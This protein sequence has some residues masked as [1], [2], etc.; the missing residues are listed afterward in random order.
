VAPPAPP[1]L[2]I[3][4]PGISGALR[5]DRDLVAGLKAGGLA[6][7]AEIV[8]WP[9]ENRGLLALGSAD[10]NREQARLLAGRIEKL[11]RADPRARIIVTA[12][13]GGT[14]VAVW[15]L[16][17]LPADVQVQTL[18]LLAS[19]LSPE[20]DLSP[21]L[22][23]VRDQ[24]LSFYSPY[25]EIVLGLGTRSLGTIDRVYTEAAGYVGFKPASPQDPTQYAKLKQFN[26]DRAWMRLGNAGEHIG[27]L[28]PM[29]AQHVIAPLAMHRQPNLD[30]PAGTDP[31]K[32][33]PEVLEPTTRKTAVPR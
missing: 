6:E 29:F 12:H 16:E 10:L 30:P 26:Y 1:S 17:L 32:P 24:A 2:L 14:G 19:A 5:F 7:Q 33:R 23:H 9:G 15:A 4:L 25:D 20:Y 22:S 28:S 27:A 13:S 18:I 11:Y 21:A 31:R 3:H 8:D